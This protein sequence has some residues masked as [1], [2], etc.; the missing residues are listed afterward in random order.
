MDQWV[1]IVSALLCGCSAGILA[2]FGLKAV[3]AVEIDNR[4]AG[5]DAVHSMPVAIRL[6]LPLLPNFRRL[7]A[8]KS[9]EAVRRGIDPK[10]WM[11]GYGEVFEAVDWL[12][13]R[14]G[15]WLTGF[16]IVIVFAAG[17]WPVLAILL[18]GVIAWYPD[19]W[20]NGCIRRRHRAII[21]AL[22][23]LLDLLTLSVEAGK[24]FMTSLKDI[25]E[26]RP[27]DALSSEFLRAL[28]EIQLGCKRSDA[29]RALSE[30]VRL[31]ELTSVL[32]AVI[33][34]EELGVS[35]AQL[36]RIQGDILRGKRFMLAEKL[37]NQAPVKIIFPIVLF[38]FPAVLLVILVPL[39]VKMLPLL[40][41]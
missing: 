15:F 2:W 32:N 25:L 35:I 17:N 36:L 41:G 27:M 10:I 34:A 29:L 5:G 4:A 18:G 14:M 8:M 28:R 40:G 13:I 23:N 20:L 33:Q 6:M 7:A 3:T 26:R 1:I 39:A 11:A 30:R 38:I 12:A 31:P 9:L 19:M 16:T 37:A 24:D 22:P 21:R